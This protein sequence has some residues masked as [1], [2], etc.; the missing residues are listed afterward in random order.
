LG[1]NSGGYFKFCFTTNI[2]QRKVRNCKKKNPRNSNCA[3]SN[4]CD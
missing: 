1:R 3:I 2:I 4:Y